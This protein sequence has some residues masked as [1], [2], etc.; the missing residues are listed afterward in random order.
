MSDEE[1]ERRREAQRERG[2]AKVN[3]E[4]RRKGESRSLRVV[5]PPKVTSG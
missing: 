1:R 2:K 4:S 3:K 5:F